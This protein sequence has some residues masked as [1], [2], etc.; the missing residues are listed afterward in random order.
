MHDTPEPSRSRVGM[1]AG[2]NLTENALRHYV[3]VVRRRGLWIVLGLVGGL[4][5]GFVTTLFIKEHKVTTHYY[6]AVN[7]LVVNGSLNGSDGSGYSLQQAS[8]LVQSQDLINQVAAQTHIPPADVGRKLATNVRGDVMALDVTAISTSADQAVLLANTAAG[9]LNTAAANAANAQFGSQRDTLYAQLNG[10]QSQRDDLQNR[11]AANPPDKDILNAQLTSVINQYSTVYSQIQQMGTSAPTFTLSTLQAA[12]A[13]E[14]NA[15]GY[16][17]RQSQIINARGQ[18]GPVQSL[19]TDFDETNLG[20][21]AP[22]DKKMRVALGGVAG[23]ILGT[24]GALLVELWD[25]RIRRRDRVEQL[26][27]LPVLAEIPRLTRDQARS[28]AVPVADSP[29]GQVAERFRAARTSILFALHASGLVGD[30]E[31]SNG[32]APTPTGAAPVVMVTSPNPSEGKSTSTASLASAFADIGMRTLVVDGDFR[33][34]SVGRFLVPVPNLLNPDHPATT[35]IDGVSFIA[36]PRDA[37]SPADAVYQLRQAIAQWR[38]HFDIILLDTPPMLTTNDAT[39]LLAAADA[40][41]LV[42]RAGQTRTGPATRVVNVLHRFRADVLGIVLNGCDKVELDAYYGYGYTYGYTRDE[43][44]RSGSNGNGNRS[45]S[46]STARTDRAD[47]G[48]EHATV[49]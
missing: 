17:Y 27:G 3:G 1:A 14:I 45:S 30:I 22:I 32:G 49:D 48:G 24:A 31:G 16:A 13:I 37:D 44:G 33:R 46:T 36:A 43:S 21:K 19:P 9:L 6:K 28:L 12:H 18:V 25:D 10:L 29:T 42:L 11:I 23:L 35:R 40:V 15:T 2:T 39:D 41:V 7:T 34:P 4:V 8:L 26:T 20:H 47:D 5:G 38:D